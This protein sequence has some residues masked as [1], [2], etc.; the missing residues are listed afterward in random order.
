[1]IK[2]EEIFAEYFKI[3][4]KFAF[5]ISANIE[6]IDKLMELYPKWEEE[7]IMKTTFEILN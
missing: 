3:T 6:S 7:K 1:M 4:K 2:N 5:N